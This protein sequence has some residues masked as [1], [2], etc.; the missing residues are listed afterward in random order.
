M[1]I[2]KTKWGWRAEFMVKGE[3]IRAKGFFKYKDEARQWV[4]DE[5][6]RLTEN[7]KRYSFQDK[8]L[9]IWTLSQKYLTD[10]K[11]NY[12]KKTVDEKRYCLKRCGVSRANG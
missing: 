8:D 11:I 4:K 5:K 7:Q 2:W 10:C 3:R 12:D 6:N 1:G 9:G